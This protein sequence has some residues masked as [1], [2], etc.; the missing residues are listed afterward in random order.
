M[1]SSTTTPIELLADVS[2]TTTISDFVTTSLNEGTPNDY[3]KYTA[4]T[5]PAAATV[6]WSD[7][8]ETNLTANSM[9]WFTDAGLEKL[10]S[11]AWTFSRQ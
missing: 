8:A 5:A 7:N 4:T 6:V 1:S 2:P 3:N 9:N 10:P 11:N